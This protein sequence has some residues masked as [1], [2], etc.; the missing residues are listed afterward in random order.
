MMKNIYDNREG[1]L[2]EMLSSNSYR[3]G[4]VRLR[5][6]I[7]RDQKAFEDRLGAILLNFSSRMNICAATA[8]AIAEDRIFFVSFKD[9][10]IS[11]N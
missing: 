10:G 11:S 2:N 4:G 1:L 7:S 9:Q 5:K 3:N 6:K 8:K